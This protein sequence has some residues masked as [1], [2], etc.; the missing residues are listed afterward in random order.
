MLWLALACGGAHDT[1]PDALRRDAT[2]RLVSSAACDACGG[3]CL[4]EN[5]TYPA[6]YHALGEVPTVDPPPAGGPHNTCWAEWGVHAEAVDDDRWVHNLEHG[7]VV[8]LW[9]CPDGCD[10]DVTAV[11][12]FASAHDRTV[13]TPYDALPTRFGIVAW[14]WRMTSACF[15]EAAAAAFYAAHFDHAPE[16][17]GSDPPPG[18]ARPSDTGGAP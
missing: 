8:L 1:D 14:D 16:S 6:R 13:A 3:D 4:I 5:L 18:C 11:D 9:S 17:T 2:P 12:A 7:G 15:D 10:A